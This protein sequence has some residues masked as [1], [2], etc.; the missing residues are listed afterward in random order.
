MCFTR[1]AAE[2]GR[3]FDSR[4]PGVITRCL[5]GATPKLNRHRS[6]TIIPI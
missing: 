4:A 1:L 6:A 2:P 5:Y 3:E